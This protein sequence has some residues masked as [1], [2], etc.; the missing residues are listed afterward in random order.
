MGGSENTYCSLI[1]KSFS[2]RPKFEYARNWR[3]NTVLFNLPY[4]VNTFHSFEWKVLY[5]CGE[6]A[7]FR[8][9]FKLSCYVINVIAN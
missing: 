9:R 1:Y 4:K 3:K 8:F 5:S 6:I 7:S 2:V